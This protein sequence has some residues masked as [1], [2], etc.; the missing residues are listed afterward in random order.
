MAQPLILVARRHAERQESV[1]AGRHDAARGRRR[2]RLVPR[3]GVAGRPRA[4]RPDRPP[5][6]RPPGR[7]GRRSRSATTS[8]RALAAT[9]PD[10]PVLIDGLTLW[11]ST[12]LGDEP[13]D[14]RPGPR[15]PGRG[16]PRRDRRAG[17]GRSSSSATRSGSGS[18]RCTPA[19]APIRDLVGLA[20]QRL[21]RPGR[22]GRTC[23]W[24]ACRSRLKGGPA[25]DA[26]RAAAADAACDRRRRSRAL[27]ADLAGSGRSTPAAMAAARGPPRP[28]DQAAGQPR[29]A[30]GPGHPAGRDHRPG[31]R[32]G[33]APAR[34]SWPPPTTASRAA[35]RLGLPGR[36]DGPDGRQL[37]RRRRGDQ[38]PR[39]RG[40]RAGSWSS[41]W[42]SPG[43]S[44]RSVPDA[45]AAAGSSARGSGPGP[46][47]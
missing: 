47:T 22:R 19:R 11:L 5:S 28:A 34:S 10:E 21:A 33:R 1:R 12:L 20:H 42:A 8:R 15:R 7:R 14:H 30:R 24:P 35:G 38:R 23:W 37:R 29:P 13:G 27:R 25:H 45:A 16:G 2:P 4:R 36:G 18:C 31:R 6:R 9:A 41:T 46:R 44:R 26:R 39:R 17:P 40:R 3:D 32:A 43:R